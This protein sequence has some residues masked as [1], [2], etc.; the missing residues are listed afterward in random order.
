MLTGI[1]EGIIA[2]VTTDLSLETISPIGHRS[3]IKVY[4][5]MH[6]F[7]SALPSV[8]TPICGTSTLHMGG[9]AMHKLKRTFLQLIRHMSHFCLT[10]ETLKKPNTPAR[11]KNGTLLL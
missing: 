3:N 5:A 6:Q 10:L 9:L 11:V 1:S 8:S 7:S 4:F 2:A